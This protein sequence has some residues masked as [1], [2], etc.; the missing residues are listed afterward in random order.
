MREREFSSDS[1]LCQG[2]RPLWMPFNSEKASFKISELQPPP[3]KLRALKQQAIILKHMSLQVIHTW[4]NFEWTWLGSFASGYNST[5]LGFKLSFGSNLFH[6]CLFW[7]TDK[8]AAVI[9]PCSQK[10][11]QS[12]REHTYQTSKSVLQNAGHPVHLWTIFSLFSSHPLPAYYILYVK[13][14][15]TFV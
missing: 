13:K 2:S 15:K 4:A 9:L 12:T 6:V 10:D 8:E 14:K 11:H 1:P 7:G 3:P 5:R